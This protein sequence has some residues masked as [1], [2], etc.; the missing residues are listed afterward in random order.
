[1]FDSVL[2]TPL[3]ALSNSSILHMTLSMI[4]H[5]IW[6]QEVGDD[7][8]VWALNAFPE[9]S[10]LECLIE[11]PPLINY[12]IFSHQGHSYSNPPAY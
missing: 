3:Y 2:N 10:T 6:E 9:I 8:R 5:F 4:T 12:S 11:V 1:M 7:L